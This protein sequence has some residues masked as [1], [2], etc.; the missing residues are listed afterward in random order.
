MEAAGAAR[1]CGVGVRAAAVR[2]AAALRHGLERARGRRPDAGFRATPVRLPG[3]PASSLRPALQATP[4][5]SGSCPPPKRRA[6]A[7]RREPARPE[8][9]ARQ[10][11][12]RP[13]PPV[14]RRRRGTRRPAA[15]RRGRRD[16][17][18]RL[19]APAVH[20]PGERGRRPLRRT[21]AGE[22][23]A[24][25]VAEAGAEDV[26][27]G[28][29]RVWT[30]RR[31]AP[32][33]AGT[34][35]PAAR[36]SGSASPGRRTCAGGCCSW[37]SRR[38]RGPSWRCSRGSGRRPGACAGARAAGGVRHASGAAGQGRCPRRAVRAPGGTVHGGGTGADAHPSRP[39]GVGGLTRRPRR[40]ARSPG[41]CPS[42]GP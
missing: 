35:C 8:Q 41:T 37:T 23:L 40:P 9:R 36:G 10:A 30:S 15:A 28:L 11:A 14:G 13:G 12:D 22:R 17:L 29:P 3:R 39:G 4:A 33:A 26:A 19:Q 38:T 20:R 1:A 5:P 7:P 32:S 34:N 2:G 27:A 42:R 25:A 16:G 31:P 21:H 18:P 6:A 24:E